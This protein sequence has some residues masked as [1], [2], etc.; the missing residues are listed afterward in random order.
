MYAFVGKFIDANFHY[1]R[2]TTFEH[3]CSTATRPAFSSIVTRYH[4]T[5][6]FKCKRADVLWVFA[7]HHMN[8]HLMFFFCFVYQNNA[9]QIVFA[10][11]FIAYT[12]CKALMQMPYYENVY[13]NCFFRV[14]VRFSPLEKLISLVDFTNSNANARALNAF[15]INKLR[16]P[17]ENAIFFCLIQF[18]QF[19]NIHKHMST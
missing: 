8:L 6:N 2:T 7:H 15:E 3:T 18:E 4:T 14:Y 9:S 5:P 13:M 11:K 1:H 19:V 12:I 17:N 16:S 10:T